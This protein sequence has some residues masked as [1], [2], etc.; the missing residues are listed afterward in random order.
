M[1]QSKRPCIRWRSRRDFLPASE[2][3]ADVGHPNRAVVCEQR[4]E[5]VVVAH[6]QRVGELAAQRVD[7]GAISDG[8]KVAHRFSSLICVPRRERSALGRPSVPA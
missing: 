6:H 1:E 7:L 5:A 8:L 3:D 4:R 2:F